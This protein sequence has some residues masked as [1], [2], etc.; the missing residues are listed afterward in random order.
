M[1]NPTSTKDPLMDAFKKEVKEIY[2]VFEAR[3]VNAVWEAIIKWI[4]H[5]RH[6]REAMAAQIRRQSTEI[7][8]LKEERDR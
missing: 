8:S 2:E 5:E 7:Y 4:A 3:E 1:E 6:D